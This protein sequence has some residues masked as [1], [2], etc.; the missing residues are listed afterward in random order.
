[1][2]DCTYCLTYVAGYHT[3]YQ[4][5]REREDPYYAQS[6]VVLN[7]EGHVASAGFF[8]PHGP[9]PKSVTY[10]YMKYKLQGTDLN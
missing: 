2:T 8:L 6:A 9:D 1:M 4:V 5:R 10:R 7:K 3:A